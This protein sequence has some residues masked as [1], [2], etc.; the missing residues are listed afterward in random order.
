MRV[1]PRSPGAAPRDARRYGLTSIVN[2]EVVF[3]M[4]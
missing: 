2:V 1:P 3:L 4:S